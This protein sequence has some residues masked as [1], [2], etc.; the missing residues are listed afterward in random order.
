[1]D[2]VEEQ[3]KAV[4][5]PLPEMKETLREELYFLKELVKGKTILDVGCGNGR[6]A[7]K[8]AEYCKELTCIDNEK[9]M[10]ELAHKKLDGY[11]NVKVILMDALKMEFENEKF[12]FIYSTYNTVGSIEDK[13]ALM[14]ELV[15]VIKPGGKIAIFT[16]K[17]D[18]I[19][20]EFMKKYYPS[21]GFVVREITDE[22][23]DLGKC[24]FER[25]DMKKLISLFEGYGLKDIKTQEIGPLWNV[26]TGEK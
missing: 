20:T 17:R 24:V 25:L 4:E 23:A 1:M 26:I 7:D 19:T 22:K 14:K 18:E 6:P 15:K 8:L 3:I 2:Y 10:I 12:D 13:N 5:N 16:W 9:R 11:D 21:I